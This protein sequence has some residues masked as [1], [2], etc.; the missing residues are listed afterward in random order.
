MKRIY[1]KR[2]P[3]PGNDIGCKG[4]FFNISKKAPHN[5]RIPVNFN[6]DHNLKKSCSEGYYIFKKVREK[7]I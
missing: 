3:D 1:I 6:Q 5:C 7:I 4:C 2:V